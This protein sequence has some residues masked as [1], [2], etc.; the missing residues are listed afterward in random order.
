MRIVLQKVSQA[1][2][3]IANETIAN[4][5]HGYM[6]LVGLSKGDTV[7]E[8]E[9]MAKK[10][11]LLRVFADD[12][13]KMWKKN[14]KEVDGEVLSVSQFTLMAKTK[15]GSKP[16]FHMAL[17]SSLAKDIYGHF[18]SCLKAEVGEDKVFDGQFGGLMSCS[19]TNEGPVTIILDSENPT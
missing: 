4:I 12:T 3:S 14:I 2:I 17:E 10:V 8:V 18:F 7:D 1:S 5:K 11:A 19:L 13:G 9:K 15:K 6:L 16:D